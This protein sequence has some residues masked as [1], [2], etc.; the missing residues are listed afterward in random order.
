MELLAPCES[1]C[2]YGCV[3]LRGMA[4][5]TNVTAQRGLPKRHNAV[6]AHAALP[7]LIGV[8][9]LASLCNVALSRNMA[10]SFTA[11]TR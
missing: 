3:R 5:S 1:L 7:I 11:F 2:E 10:S 8:C 4:I 6:S 9:G